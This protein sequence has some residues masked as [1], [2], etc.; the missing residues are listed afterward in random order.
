MV[1]PKN[2][3]RDY[4]GVMQGAAGVVQ[5]ATQRGDQEIPIDLIDINPQVRTQFNPEK[6]ASINASIAAQGINQPLIL[7]AKPNGRY[8]LIAGEYRIRGA[9]ANVLKTVPARVKHNLSPWEIRRI[10][11][12]ENMERE[13]ISAFDEAMGVAED[14]EKY[15]FDV[16][17]DIWNRSEGWISKR[18]AVLKYAEPVRKLLQDGISND[19]EVA[20]S[21]NQLHQLDE[22]EYGR[23]EKRLREGIPLSRDEV[24]GKVQQVKQWQS[25]A[26]QRD[27][28]RQTLG[29]GSTKDKASTGKAAAPS[30]AS[31]QDK[32]TQTPPPRDAAPAAAAPA[33]STAP[34]AANA[35]TASTSV[36]QPAAA[37]ADNQVDQQGVPATSGDPAPRISHEQALVLEQMVTLFQ[38]GLANHRLV[39]DVQGEL[40]ELGADMN[41]TE[42]ALWTLFQTSVLPLLGALGEQ[43]SQRYLQR[44]IAELRTTKAQELWSKLHPTVDGA[45]S[46]DWSAT[47]T[48]VAPMPKDW[49]F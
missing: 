25:E 22:Q 1:K 21:L 6:Q 7:H 43:R 13:D 41:Q 3:L 34:A 30:G 27:T 16:A 32:G 38:S 45:P 10:Q 39:N 24:R 44:T 20:H 49:Q 42:W 15:G 9:F 40:A 31:T 48:P 37:A 46:D 35:A 19:L 23:L 5:G 14:V 11:V 29:Q 17:K 12:S 2:K 47:R 4:A 28:R 8:D 36:D 18:T 26:K 33:A